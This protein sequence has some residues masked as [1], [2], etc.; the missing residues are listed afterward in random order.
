MANKQYKDFSA[1]AFANDQIIA[2]QSTSDA[3]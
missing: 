3:S 2:Q 1:G